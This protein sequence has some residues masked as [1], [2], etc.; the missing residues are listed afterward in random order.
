MALAGAGALLSGGALWWGL[1]RAGNAAYQR[2]RPWLQWQVGRVM[3]HPLELGPYRGLRPWGLSAGASRFRP[4]RDNPSTVDT[5]GVTVSFDP[6]RSLLERAWVLRIGLRDARVVLRPNSR[7][8]YWE[9]GRLPPGRQPPPLGLH[10]R[11]DGAAAVRL[12]P[13]VGQPVALRL[14]GESRMH[15]RR[16]DLSLRGLARPATGGQLGFGLEAN[17][18]QRQWALQL[19]PRRL[20]ADSVVPLLPAGL[21]Q[22]LA[23]RLQGW[24]DGHLRVRHGQGCQG[25]L[26]LSGARWRTAL[27]PAPLQSD[28]LPLRC[29]QDRLQLD[30]AAMAMGRWRG[31]LQGT[32]AL[33][34]PRSGALQ[35]QLQARELGRGHR[36]IARVHGPWRR[37]LVDLQGSVQGLRLRD[38]PPLPLLLDGRLALAFQPRPR[39]RLERLSLR[40]GDASLE[41]SGSLWPQL[42]V[43]SHRIHTGRQLLRPL[44][45][46]IGPAPRLRAEVLLQ[47]PWRRPQ[48]DLSLRQ[49]DHP[50]L[51]PFTAQLR[52]LPG[53]LRLESLRAAELTAS[54]RL[55]LVQGPGDGLR[56]GPLSL[57]LDLRRYRLG[58]LSALIGSRLRGELEA[59]GTIEG[60]LQAL[61]PDLRLLVRRPGVGP[62]QLEEIWQGRLVGAA[63]GGADLAL[64]PQAPAS[65]A[66]LQAR[67]DRRWLPQWVRLT[68][69]EGELAFSGS[70]RRYRWQASRFP[71]EGLH[72]ALGPRGGLQPLQGLLSGRG[73]LDLQ[74][75]WI[76][77]SVAVER[78]LLAGLSGR[79]L[80]ASGWYRQ[81]RYGAEGQWQADR[82]AQ[83]AIRLRG[84]QG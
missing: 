75:L 39:V 27:L 38:Q 50:L 64:Q 74:P 84:R 19:L 60:P 42:L 36:L 7:G 76:R 29:L 18:L 35:L 11:L 45:P 33:R 37:P 20:P 81:R 78:P 67:L 59:W 53:L 40:R 47:G 70:P 63:G 77:A 52:W 14:E 83:V 24:M 49:A 34:G 21:Q 9:L 68:R 51:G 1:D 13:S 55:P 44:G 26:I 22:Q 69:S 25:E 10:I 56:A 15:L 71:L 82:G 57:R 8:A 4:G 43:R 46:I 28:R 73:E 17:W 61:R 79:R 23:G 62:L 2:L 58:R 5:T 65:P 12:M 31:R 30:G 32:L 6:L 48:L 3:G 16:R 54:G 80:D 72:L 41:A 66:D